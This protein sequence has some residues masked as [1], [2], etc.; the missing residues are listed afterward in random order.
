[1]AVIQIEHLT[2]RYGTTA[3]VKD[4]TLDMAPEESQEAVNSVLRAEFDE[5]IATARVELPLDAPSL[6]RAFEIWDERIG[7]GKVN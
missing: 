3:A 2:K 6:V 7:S 5:L 1:M 4:V